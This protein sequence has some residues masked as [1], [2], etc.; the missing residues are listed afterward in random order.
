V[1][2]VGNADGATAFVNQTLRSIVG[3][4]LCSQMASFARPADTNAYSAGDVVSDN[5]G[6]A[7]ALIFPACGRGG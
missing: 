3:P 5:A 1:T 2:T 6:T 7:K 4:E